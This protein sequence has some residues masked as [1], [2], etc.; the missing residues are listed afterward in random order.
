MR[1]LVTLDVAL[2]GRTLGGRPLAAELG[3]GCGDGLA[4]GTLAGIGLGLTR[5]PGTAEIRSFD[6][7]A[8]SSGVSLST[9]ELISAW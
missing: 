2:G 9:P 1:E 4:P 8:S 5:A 6:P 3:D 7:R